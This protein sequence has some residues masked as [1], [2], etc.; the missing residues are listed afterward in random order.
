MH[1]CGWLTDGTQFDSTYVGGE[2]A[3]VP[4]EMVVPGFREGLR[5]MQPGAIFRLTI[6]AE[7]AYGEVGAGGVVPPNAALVFTVTLLGIEQPR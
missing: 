6:P 5:R 4:L 2:P 3:T 7:L 1:Y